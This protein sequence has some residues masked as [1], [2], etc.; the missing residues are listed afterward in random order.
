[1]ALRVVLSSF[2][3][4]SPWWFSSVYGP[5]KQGGDL[6]F[7]KSY[8]TFMVCVP[9]VSVL[10]VT[11]MLFGFHR[12]KLG[13]GHLNSSVVGFDAFIQDCNLQD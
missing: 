7:G 12:K 2:R 11:L 1:M 6:Y 10:T 13:G 5:N 9:L 4:K 8:L 3:G